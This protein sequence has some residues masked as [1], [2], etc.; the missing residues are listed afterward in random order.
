VAIRF[1]AIAGNL[2]CCLTGWMA[3]LARSAGSK[4]AELLVL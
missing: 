3:L 1:P 4:D 2:P